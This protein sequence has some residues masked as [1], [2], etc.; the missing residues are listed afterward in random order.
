[1]PVSPQCG[2]WY[3]DFFLVLVDF[4]VVFLA[5]A[6][7]LALVCFFDV[8]ALATGFAAAGA[9]AGS[10]ATAAGATGAA[11]AAVCAMLSEVNA[12]AIVTAISFFMFDPVVMKE[13]G[14]LVY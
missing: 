12:A 13:A 3:Q 11:G 7:L 1:M 2:L 8:F 14:A 5:L 4:F 9:A 6:G 10:A